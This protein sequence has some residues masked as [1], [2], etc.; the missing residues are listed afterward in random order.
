MSKFLCVKAGLCEK[1]AGVNALRR[2]SQMV[3]P[4][5]AHN[6]LEHAVKRKTNSKQRGKMQHFR[7]WGGRRKKSE[8]KRK[9]EENKER[10]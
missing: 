6:G 5:L 9:E 8:E 3:L 1:L 4:G 2:K 10:E 7:C